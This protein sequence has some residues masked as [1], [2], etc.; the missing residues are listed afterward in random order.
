MARISSNRMITRRIS[1]LKKRVKFDTQQ[2]RQK[3][4]ISL[5]ELFD[6]SVTLAKGQIK[7]Q[8]EGDKKVTVTLKQ[9]QMWARIAAYIGQIMS[10]VASGFDE[11]EID[12]QLEEL[13]KLVGEAITKGKDQGTEATASRP[14][15]S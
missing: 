6:L 9:R 1:K 2:I 5:Q 7:T 14:S 4:I 8:T 3:T 13:E 15:G 10:S 11:R 12:T